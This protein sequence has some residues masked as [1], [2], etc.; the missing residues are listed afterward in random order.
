MP[1]TQARSSTQEIQRHA[2]SGWVMLVVNILLL[3]GGIALLVLGIQRI[4]ATRQFSWL[5]ILAPVVEMLA[6]ILLCGH[7]TLQPNEARVLIL[8]GD[9]ST[10]F[11]ISVLDGVPDFVTMFKNDGNSIQG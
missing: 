9:F 5:M 1:N 3:L 4:D 8:F 2:L 6:I 7:F 10:H 11:S